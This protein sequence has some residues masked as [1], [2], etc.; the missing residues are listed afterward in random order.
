MLNALLFWYMTICCI[1]SQFPLQGLCL[2]LENLV[3]C[4]GVIMLCGILTP[5]FLFV[6]L[7]QVTGLLSFGSINIDFQYHLHFA[8]LKLSQI[9]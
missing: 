1:P 5:A 2:T 3:F 9:I 8:V 4:H 7:K 6:P